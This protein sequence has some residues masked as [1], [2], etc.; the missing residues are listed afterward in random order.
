MTEICACLPSP[1]IEELSPGVQ[2]LQMVLVEG[3]EGN[4]RRGPELT[5]GGMWARTSVHLGHHGH[6]NRLHEPEA[7]QRPRLPIPPR[8]GGASPPTPDT[9]GSFWP[10]RSILLLLL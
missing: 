8:S 3:L 7:G 4:P 1:C 10:G 2:S 5:E 6:R 9:D